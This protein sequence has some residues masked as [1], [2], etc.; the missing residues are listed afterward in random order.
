M[1][2]GRGS[3]GAMSHASA[4]GSARNTRNMCVCSLKS[5][6]R[7]HLRDQK[8]TAEMCR[9][10]ACAASDVHPMGEEG[11]IRTFAEHGARTTRCAQPPMATVGNCG[12]ML[13]GSIR[14]KALSKWLKSEGK[15]EVGRDRA[16]Q[17]TLANLSAWSLTDRESA[18]VLNGLATAGLL[19]RN[20]ANDTW[21]DRISLLICGE[22]HRV[23]WPPE[24]FTVNSTSTGSRIDK[25]MS[26]WRE[27]I[28]ADVVRDTPQKIK[29]GAVA[30]QRVPAHAALYPP[31]ALEL[32]ELE[33]A[34]IKRRRFLGKSPARAVGA[35]ADVRV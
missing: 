31:T 1:G 5:C 24:F 16:H 11:C 9:P 12:T 34:S 28:P 7:E 26:K 6:S 17:W 21:Q 3:D 14:A 25:V 20:N 23:H 13:L 19:N 30:R 15:D 10:I 29:D 4:S 22:F 18:D 35:K 27:A 8:W 2:R 33:A 32:E